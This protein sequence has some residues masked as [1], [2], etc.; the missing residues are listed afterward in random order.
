MNIQVARRRVRTAA[1]VAGLGLNTVCD[2]AMCPNRGE[3]FAR[4]TATFLLLGD[5]CTR[6]CEFCGVRHGEAPAPLASD[7]PLR[8]ATAVQRMEIRHVVLTCVTRDDLDDGGASHFVETVAAI[9]NVAAD[10]GVPVPTVEVL[11]SDFGG[12]A[13]AV[14]QLAMVV[15]DVYAYNTETV[16]RLYATVRDRRTSYQTTL[17]VFRT[18]RRIA[19]TIP[20]KTGMMLGLGETVAELLDCWS[21]LLEYGVTRLTLGQYLRPGRQQMSVVRYYSPQEF[22]E[23]AALARSLGF[24][25]VLAGRLVRS[26]Y[27][28]EEML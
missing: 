3:C 25:H 1:A 20:L 13:A 27:H 23:L 11:P 10:A 4:G 2:A 7:E 22:D 16:P 8:V 26:S 17:D 15:P 18:V 21:E 5:R 14:E 6:S 19:P 28:A 9:R 24:R 12:N